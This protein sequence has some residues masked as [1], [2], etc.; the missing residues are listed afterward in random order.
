MSLTTRSHGEDKSQE[1]FFFVDQAKG[2]TATGLIS[3]SVIVQKRDNPFLEGLCNHFY[4][5]RLGSQ[6]S[7]IIRVYIKMKLDSC[8]HESLVSSGNVRMREDHESRN[9]CE[10]HV[11]SYALP[12]HYVCLKNWYGFL[13]W[14]IHF[15]CLVNLPI[16]EAPAIMVKRVLS[17]S[18]SSP[19]G[20]I[21]CHIFWKFKIHKA[22]SSSQL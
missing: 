15:D 3:F 19:S 9:S 1:L 5:L 22:P 17:T 8:N 13:L 14:S 11:P 21:T 18:F 6:R 4:Y 7:E 20:W 12:V 16:T 10:H 2:F